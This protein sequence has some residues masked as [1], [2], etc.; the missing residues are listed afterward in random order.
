MKHKVTSDRLKYAMNAAN[1]N[2]RSLASL[3]KVS[4]A[5]ISQYINGTHKPGN[6]SSGKIAKVLKCSPL[7]LMGFDVPMNDSS[8]PDK[9]GAYYVGWTENR[10]STSDLREAY[11]NHLE[12]QPYYEMIK[13][14]M[15]RQLLDV[16]NECNEDEINAAIAFI[17][18]YKRDK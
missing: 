14:P 18:F 13:R 8:K 3:S 11:I 15:I 6:I 7:W 17:Q 4:E 9:D 5:S 2:A 10:S 1:I 12:T 16:A